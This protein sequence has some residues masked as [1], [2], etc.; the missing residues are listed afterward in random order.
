MS[1]PNKIPPGPNEDEQKP[2]LERSNEQFQERATNALPSA[3][4]GYS[5]I[6]SILLFGLIGYGIDRW[7]GGTSHTFLLIG[8]FLGVVVGFF[9]LIKLS[10][11]R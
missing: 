9:D 7:R 10:R 5:L 2:F 4:A 11:R 3:L 8:V 1:R 6:G